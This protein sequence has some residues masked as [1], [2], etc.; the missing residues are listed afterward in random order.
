MPLNGVYLVRQAAM[1]DMPNRS[2]LGRTTNSNGCCHGTPTISAG[3]KLGCRAKHKCPDS[4]PCSPTT[5][6]SMAWMSSTNWMVF[7]KKFTKLS[8]SSSPA[9]T[10]ATATPTH[11]TF[12]SENLISEKNCQRSKRPP[13]M[14]S[15]TLM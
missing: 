3:G 4:N 6:S 13:T 7:E 14:A 1:I 10:A 12:P 5:S 11:C 8:S 9:A 2:E 15:P